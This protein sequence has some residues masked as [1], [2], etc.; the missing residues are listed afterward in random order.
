[1]AATRRRDGVLARLVVTDGPWA[2][3]IPPVPS[4]FDVTVSFSS[5]ALGDEHAEALQLLGYRVVHPPPV[6]AMPLPPVADFLIGEA[7]LDRHPTYGRSFAEQAKRAYNLAF[8]PAAALVAD[9]VEAH[10]GIASS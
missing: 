9:V 8:G 2:E 6:T 7:L 4:G 3:T 10:T 1:M 5:E